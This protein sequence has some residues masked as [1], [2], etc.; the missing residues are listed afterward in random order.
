MTLTAASAN[1]GLW[2]FDRDSNE[3]WAT[4]HGKS[5]IAFLTP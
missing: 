1:I 2:Q 5:S 3:L 4:E